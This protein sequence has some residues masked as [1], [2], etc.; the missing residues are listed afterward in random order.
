MQINQERVLSRL[1]EMIQIDSVSYHEGPMTDYLQSYFESLGYEVYRDEAGKA[2][3]GDH[4]GNLLVHIPGTLKGEA[5]CL[6]AHQDT[7]EPGIGI[8]P[9]LENGILK[10]S[11]DTILAADDKSGIA[12]MI[13]LLELLRETKTPH[14]DLYY[15]FTICEENGMY[16]AKS[17][18]YSKL[19]AKNIFALD[20]AGMPGT[21]L[22][23]GAGKDSLTV[24]FHGKTAH[25]GIEPEKG[26]NAIAVAASAISRVPFGRIDPETTS[27]IG[28]I[29]GGGAT[30]IVTDTVTFTCEVRSH[31]KEQID[32]QVEKI[33]SAC[34]AAAKEF[35]ATVTI[36]IDHFCP[37]HKPDPDCFLSRIMLYAMEQEGFV[38]E[39][40][41][42]NG[43]GDANI[44]SGHGFN[45][46]GISTGMFDVHTTG[47]YLDME[48]FTRV[49]RVVWRMLTEEL[50]E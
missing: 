23:S 31:T 48:L 43:S 45:C 22:K 6:N 24:T 35:G 41:V 1:I 20:G 4:A 47:E 46:S 44:F 2:I 9:V 39:Y 17:F 5:I 18:D 29:E 30:N 10:S 12:M 32:A 7:V 40:K 26:I 3:G 28:R 49:C 11:G 38:P 16:G 27:N 19:P 13:E 33:V 36:D 25:G 34:Q 21:V 50:P 14:R 37:P 8:R 42:S 15:L